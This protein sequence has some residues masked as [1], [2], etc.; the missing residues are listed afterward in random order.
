MNNAVS[1]RN[2][3]KLSGAFVAC[4]IGS[5]F[6][7]GQEIL[8]FFAGQG[9]MSIVGTFVTTVFF[10]WCGGMFMKHG[11]EHRLESPVKILEFYFGKK[12]GKYMETVFQIFLYGVYVIMIADAGA[13]ISEYFGFNPMVGRIGM[14][15]FA[16]FT[17]IFGLTRVGEI[18]GGLGTVIIVFTL[19]VGVWSFITNI[20]HIGTA[21]EIIPSLD[22]TR[23]PGGWLG[24]SILYPA[25]NAISLDRK[26]VV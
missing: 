21:A 20:G 7:T 16:F 4:A 9:L 17:V 25:Y 11:F 24:S 18:L 15:L 3:I 12:I 1:I 13:T 14:A 5:G 26:S 19:S 2:V 8:Q 23:A 22:I 10:A 6:A